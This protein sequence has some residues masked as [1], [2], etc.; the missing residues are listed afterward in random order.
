LAAL[1]IK[2][3]HSSRKSP[4]HA[5]NLSPVEQNIRDMALDTVLTVLCSGKWVAD[6]LKDLRTLWNGL[7]YRK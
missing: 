6:P 1:N 4:D 3:A 2:L 5:N 7:F